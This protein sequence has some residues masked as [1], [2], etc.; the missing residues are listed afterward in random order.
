LDLKTLL[1]LSTL[2]LTG[3]SA[4][5]ETVGNE[6]Q[7]NRL[8]EA[9]GEAK[10]YLQTGLESLN[11]GWDLAVKNAAKGTIKQVY[12]NTSTAQ[13]YTLYSLNNDQTTE[14]DLAKTGA[15]AAADR[16]VRNP[17]AVI[18][19]FAS[20]NDNEE[21]RGLKIALVFE[22]KLP[23]ESLIGQFQES[24]FKCVIDSSSGGVK[25]LERVAEF[26]GLAKDAIVTDQDG[27]QIYDIRPLLGGD[28]PA[29]I[30][31]KCYAGQ[32]R[33]GTGATGELDLNL[34]DSA[35]SFPKSSTSIDWKKAT[36]LYGTD[37][38]NGILILINQKP[39]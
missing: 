14:F 10:S 23:Y 16:S 3:L 33:R 11:E 26:Q 5:A 12:G 19:Q 20:T 2:S 29:G 35:L 30:F 28:K 37:G 32:F 17:N 39:A 38:T 24:N 27:Y 34:G 8:E 36:R 4:H 7:L 31:S 6:Y 22:K 18:V 13:F 25:L 1:L 15:I 21:A 9:L